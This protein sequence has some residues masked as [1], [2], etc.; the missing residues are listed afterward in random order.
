MGEWLAQELK[1]APSHYYEPAL[2]WEA[3][4]EISAQQTAYDVLNQKLEHF[5]S[6]SKNAD[7][8]PLKR[9]LERL[10]I[11]GRVILP[12]QGANYL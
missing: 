5:I 2:A 10:S 6:E 3:D 12:K 11:T 4:V 7:V 1:Q 8:L 9:W